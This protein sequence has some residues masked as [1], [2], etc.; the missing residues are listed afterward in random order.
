MER[1]PAWLK[2]RPPTTEQF[3][4]IRSLVATKQLHTVCEEAHCPNM[5][6]CWS[7]GTA[8]FMVL[9]AVCTRGCRFCEVAS[10]QPLPPDPQEPARI[11][12]AITA[13]GLEYAV[14]TTVDRDDLPDQGAGHI[15]ACIRA[16]K[17]AGVLVE[18]LAPDFRGQLELVDRVLEAGPVVF[19]HNIETVERLQA[20][21]RDRRAGYAQ[22]LAVLAHAK[23]RG[24]LT[25]SSLMVGLGE[26]PEEVA[27]ALADLRAAG[28]D[29]V[30]IGQYLRP[31]SWHLPVAEYVPP[32]QFQAYERLAKELGFRYCASGP[33]VR[34]S[35]KAG[36]LFVKNVIRKNGALPML[37]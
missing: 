1:K 11:A 18:V 32:E 20:R 36:E 13:M 28:V 16:A 21:V 10:G 31:S 14:L 24:F 5:S 22:S 9:G 15:A 29:L 8:T 26:R 17:A 6:E 30:T 12:E 33:F 34:S 2:I 19:A 4:Q 23:Q 3:A 35:Y 27:Q 25:K 7:G 37:A